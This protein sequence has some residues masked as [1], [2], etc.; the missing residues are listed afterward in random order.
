MKI[1]LGQVFIAIVLTGMSYAKTGHAQAVLEKPVTISINNLS[2]SNALKKLEKNADIKFVYS[3]SIIQTSQDVSIESTKERLE[4]VLSRLL[5]PNGI[6]FEVIN[7]RIVLVKKAIAPITNIIEAKPA[8]NYA[9]DI[10]AITVRGVVTSSEGEVLP[11]VSV[12]VKGTSSGTTTDVNGKYSINLPNGDVTLVF[13]YIGYAPQEIAVNGQTQINVSLTGSNKSLNEVVVIGYQSVK[14]KDLTGAVAVISAAESKRISSNSLAESIQGLSPGVSI[15]T[16]GNPGGQADVQIRG[17]G[18]F[19]G[20]TPLYIIDGMYAD[21]NPTINNDDI[22]SIQILKDASASAIYGSRAGNG[23]IIITTKKGKQ[24]DAVINASAKYGVQEIPKRWNVMD[25]S[26]YA[27]L[28]KQ[29]YINSGLTPV[30]SVGDQY[31]PSIN[32]N[33]Q[34][35]IMRTGAIQD[36]NLALSGGTEK[37]K[38]LISGSYFGNKGTLIG[39]KFDRSSLRVNTET[40]KGILTFGENML[41]TNSIA[42]N[43]A[44]GNPFYDMP[45]QLPVIPVKSAKYI[46]DTNPA[47]WGIGTTDAPSYAWNYLAINDYDQRK[48]TYTKLVGNAFIDLKFTSWLSYRFNTGAEVSFDDNSYLRKTGIWAYTQQPELSYAEN[49]REKFT[50]ILLEHTLNFN[51]TFSKHS[52]NGVLG[53]TEQRVLRTFLDGRKNGLQVVGGDYFTTINSANGL[54]SVTGGVNEGQDYRTRGYLGRVNYGYDDKYLLTLTGRI[55]QDSR[56]GANYRTGYFP[57][58]AGAWR[59]SRESFFHVDWVNDLK[60]SASYGRLGYNSLGS[61][62]NQALLNS[63]QRAVFGP[64]QFPYVGASQAKLNNP[65]LRWETRIDKNVGVAAT[66]FNNSLTVG[67]DAYDNLSKDIIL[68]LNIPSFLGNQQ[69]NPST[70]A[71]SISN[72]GIEFEATYRHNTGDFKWDISGNFTTIKNKVVSLGKQLGSSKYFQT[73]ATRSQIGGAIGQWYVVKTEGLFQSQEEINNYKNSGGKIIQPN[74]KPGDVKFQDIN[75][76]GQIN[77]DD[78]Q[79][80]GSSIPKFQAGF[81]FNGSYKSFSINVQLVALTGY[82]IYNDVRR[83]LDSYDL[84]NFRADVS[85]WTPTNT[86]TNDP[87]IGILTNDPGLVDNAKYESSRWLENGSYLR[88][89]NLEI[90]YSFPTSLVK[91]IGVANAKVFLSGQNLHTFTKYTGLDPDVPG[92][93]IQDRG[94]D[95]GTWPPSRIYSLGIQCGF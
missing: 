60:I 49:D 79:F 67:I 51:K 82:K 25:A 17:I 4:S 85:P 78:R 35:E 73:G 83:H 94:I 72:K 28:E 12:M 84:T 40:K 41:L 10:Q 70:N 8:D 71:G 55:D 92:A 11:G 21:A 89:R 48:S 45:Q 47:G 30:G 52:I 66:L 15:R 90:G 39:N 26:H 44:A 76:D 69:G 2:L 54:A 59:I 68:G 37:S 80:D 20:T 81:Q 61:F 7:E 5:A 22:E 3:K 27:A 9:G 56:F 13:N 42:N 75:D 24:G 93:G 29:A 63:A 46:T 34:D 18:S 57:S 58:V 16:S 91:Q 74:A 38:Y 14:K 33:W 53:Y 65:D 50:N 64:N 88:I 36:Y 87:R 23:V 62:D 6:G 86:N 1:T 32:T 43:P 77:N 31:D 19:N 95:N